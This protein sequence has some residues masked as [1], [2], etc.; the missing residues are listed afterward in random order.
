MRCGGH[1]PKLQDARSGDRIVTNSGTCTVRRGVVRQVS[2]GDIVF[3]KAVTA[4]M[5]GA[6]SSLDE[7]L[8]PANWFSAVYVD[9]VRN[10]VRLK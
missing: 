9:S 4:L 2:V 6:V 1:C 7:G 3:P 10:V 8:L 5:D